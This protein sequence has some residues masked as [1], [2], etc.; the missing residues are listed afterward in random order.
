MV[1]DLEVGMAT[2]FRDATMQNTTLELRTQADW[3]RFTGIQKNARQKEQDEKTSLQRDKPQLLAEAR[4]ALIDKAGS[5]THEHPT[6]SGTDRFNKSDIDR[7]AGIKIENVHQARLL[8]IKQDEAEAYSTLKE[9][10]RARE[11]VRGNSRE[12]YTQA[13]DRRSGP[14]RRQPQR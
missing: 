10:I 7:Q 6:P 11:G 9:D 12:A 14:D 5:L 4:Q 13:I 3:D 2:M 1:S 8:G